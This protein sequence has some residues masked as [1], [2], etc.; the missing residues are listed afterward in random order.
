MKLLRKGKKKKGFTLIE[1]IAVIAILLILAI[2]LV[3]NIIG[4]MNNTKIAKVKNDAKIVLDVI[5][6]AQSEADDNTTITTYSQAIAKYPDLAPSKTPATT[7]QNKTID[8]LQTNII[9]N[10]STNFTSVYNTYY[11][12]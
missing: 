9:D 8:D 4:Y 6:T 7:L 1:L 10:N 3:P 5:K 12:K 11:S 2:F